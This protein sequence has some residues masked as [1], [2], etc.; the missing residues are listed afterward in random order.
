MSH[1][2]FMYDNLWDL[3]TI[4]TTEVANFPATNTQHRWWQ[5]TF[6]ST[7][8][9]GVYLTLS[10]SGAMTV[11]VAAI[12]YNNLTLTGTPADVK[13]FSDTDSAFSPPDPN[14]GGLSFP[15]LSNNIM[16]YY[17]APAGRSRQYWLFR[18]VDTI[19]ADSYIELGRIFLGP[20]FEPKRNYEPGGG[21]K[22][23]IDPS[24]MTTGEEGHVSSILHTKLW[25]FDYSFPYVTAADLL[26]F[27][28]MFEAMGLSRGFFITE[29]PAYPDS[30]TYY[31]RFAQPMTITPHFAGAFSVSMSLVESM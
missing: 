5:K 4:S 12:K 9:A 29:D 16:I 28:S 30:S 18:I 17:F 2:R 31:V 14:D 21:R 8:I 20:Y 7:D 1:I 19:N 26:S 15:T 24:V 11:Q 22:G 23:R 27:T 3:G 10:L 6:R 13:I 25:T